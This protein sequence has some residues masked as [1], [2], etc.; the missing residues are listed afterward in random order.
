MPTF[1]VLLN[2]PQV[3]S[4]E[5]RHPQHTAGS[6]MDRHHLL[7]PHHPHPLMP[8]IHTCLLQR[9]AWPGR[10]GWSRTASTQRRRYQQVTSS[11]HQPSK[12]HCK[13]P[14]VERSK[15]QG[16][17]PKTSITPLNTLEGTPRREGAMHRREDGASIRWLTIDIATRPLVLGRAH[18]PTATTSLMALLGGG[19]V[20]AAWLVEIPRPVHRPQ[21]TAGGTRWR[22]LPLMWQRP[23]A[24]QPHGQR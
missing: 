23:V 16:R 6:L 19:H 21:R 20:T 7:R 12:A 2:H 9:Q 3:T 17:N 1:T 22:S 18:Q 11:G 14:C 5:C 13:A 4:W 24:A 8:S 10:C 15:A